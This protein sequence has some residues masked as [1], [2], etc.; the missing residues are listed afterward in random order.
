MFTSSLDALNDPRDI[1]ILPNDGLIAIVDTGNYCI[2]AFNLQNRQANNAVTLKECNDAT[3]TQKPI[4]QN[5][6]IEKSP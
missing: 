5:I 3:L 1:A 2:K 6:L 4:E